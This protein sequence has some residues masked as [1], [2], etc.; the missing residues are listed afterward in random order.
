MQ[1]E[2]ILLI[3][4]FA[5][6]IIVLLFAIAMG[7]HNGTLSMPYK[8]DCDADAVNL[9]PRHR[10]NNAKGSYSLSTLLPAGT[11][12]SGYTNYADVTGNTLCCGSSKID[13]YNHTCQAPG[14]EGI[15][16]MSPGIE[17]TRNISG[18]IRHYPVCQ[19][20]SYQQQQERSGN[21]CPMKYPSHVNI[22]GA[23]GQYKCCAGSLQAGATDCIGNSFCS[24]LVGSQNM[25]NTPKSCETERLFEKIMCP[26]GTHMIP[27]MP[28]T[29]E[30]TKGLRLP[31]CVG[32][33]GN[34][35]PRRALDELRNLGFFQDINPDKNVMNCDVYSKIY[36]DRIWTQ[37]QAEMKHSVDLK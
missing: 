11:C 12:P 21:Y 36:N 31:V 33:K 25:F 27:D 15:C 22:P 3:T 35:I 29:N 9:P 18:D 5:G 28:G 7:I 24:G 26:P 17:D 37:S 10:S 23:P 16:S 20:I 4:G 13:I 2:T 32:V 30:R 6:I 1:S 19:K 8:Q 34:C 14:T